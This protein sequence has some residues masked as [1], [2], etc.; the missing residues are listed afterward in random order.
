MDLFNYSRRETIEV[1]IGNTALGGNNPIRVQSMTNVST[2]DVEACVAQA[3]RIVDAGGEYVRLTTQGVREAESL[4]EINAGLRKDGYDVPLVA[5]VHFNAKVADVAALYAEKVRINPG[6][7][8]DPGRTFKHLEYTDEEYAEE[9]KKIESRF[10]PFLNICR[11]NHTAIRIG[12]NHGSLSDRIMS[13]Y[14]DTPE[15]MVESCMEFL[16]ICVREN[17]KDVV[18]S[19]KASNTVVMVRTVRLLVSVMEKEGMKFPL[20]L[21]VTEAGEKYLS[22]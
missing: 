15:G 20:H 17:F 22:L 21:G 13:R 19:I 3:K 9:I 2:N 14:G 18:I 11:Q 5:D 10:V 16:R 7:Y 6:N 8:V 1:Y 12:V 4:K